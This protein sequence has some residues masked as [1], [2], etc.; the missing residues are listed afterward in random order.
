MID[1]DEQIVM[2]QYGAYNLNDCTYRNEDNL[3]DGSF[4]IYKG[5]L[6]KPVIHEKIKKLSGGRRK[7]FI[8]RILCTVPYEELYKEGKI[9]IQ[10]CSNCWKTSLGNKDYIA[11]RLVEKVFDTYQQEGSLPIRE[12][13]HM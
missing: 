13:V 5:S 6:V 7:V 1:Q 4:L 12:S 3:Q 10:N 11:W 9:E 2:Y 8:K